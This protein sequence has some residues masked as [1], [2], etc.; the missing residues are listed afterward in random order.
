MKIA[1]TIILVLGLATVVFTAQTV[2][3]E[4]LVFHAELKRYGFL[5]DQEL[6]R[7]SLNFLSDSLVLVTINELHTIPMRKL[8]NV[9][10]RGGPSNMDSPPSTAVLF[11]LEAQKMRQTAAIQVQKYADNVWAV[12]DNH[13]LILNG[14]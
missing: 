7:S 3:C 1:V 9:L 14:S 5:N 6:T 13:F 4:E 2:H 12:R 10:A 11:D 8:G